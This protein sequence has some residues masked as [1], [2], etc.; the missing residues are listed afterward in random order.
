MRKLSA[1]TWIKKTKLK[2]KSFDIPKL[3]KEESNDQKTIEGN[4]KDK[5]K[6]REIL[7]PYT[8]LA[9]EYRIFAMQ[10]GLYTSS[11]ILTH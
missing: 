3:N 4:Q 5:K 7:L 6:T 11:L 8:I 10:H 1:N 2:T 9:A